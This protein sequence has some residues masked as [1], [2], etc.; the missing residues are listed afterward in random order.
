M[1]PARAVIIGLLIGALPGLFLRS[2]IRVVDDHPREQRL[3]PAV[4]IKRT[5]PAG[6]VLTMDDVGLESRPEALVTA[7]VVKPQDVS[8]VVNQT[9]LVPLAEGDLLPWS[10]FEAMATIEGRPPA[11]ELIDA[12]RAEMTRRQVPAAPASVSGLRAAL[13]EAR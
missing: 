13:V 9:L 3:S 8:Y 2:L 11:R 6:H 10:V 1:P 7:S 4:V 5:L 12:C